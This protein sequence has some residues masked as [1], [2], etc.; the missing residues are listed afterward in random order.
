MQ[1]RHIIETVVVGI[2]C[3]TSA[4]IMGLIGPDRAY[5]AVVVPN[6]NVNVYG[7]NG[8]GLQVNRHRV[9]LGSSLAHCHYEDGSGG[10][11]PC[12]WNVGQP[13]DGNGIGLA[14]WV[15]RHFHVHYV[16]AHSPVQGHPANHWLTRRERVEFRHHADGN[17][18]RPWNRCYLH[19]A[20]TDRVNCPNGDWYTTS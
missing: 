8:T 18:H 3:A 5:P 2:A 13:V 19:T 11:R 10:P 14:Y 16:W 4:V 20:G 9:V 6:G 7:A 1:R 12:T 15:G 17:H